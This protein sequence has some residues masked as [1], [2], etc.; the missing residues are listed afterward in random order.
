MKKNTSA[1]DMTVK[2]ESEQQ[3]EADNDEEEVKMPWNNKP[4]SSG[5]DLIQY[6]EKN[7]V[8][9]ERILSTTVVFP[10]IHPRQAK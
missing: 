1:K 8:G 3:D 6:F 10:V 4:P 9:V 5:E 7:F 2:Q